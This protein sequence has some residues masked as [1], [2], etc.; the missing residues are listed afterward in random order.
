MAT[1]H[2]KIIRAIEEF[3]YFL[4]Y[5]QDEYYQALKQIN[6]KAGWNIKYFEN[7]ILQLPIELH[8]NLYDSIYPKL[9]EDSPATDEEIVHTF[10]NCLDHFKDLASVFKKIEKA[11][12]KNDEDKVLD[13]AEGLVHEL[14]L[15]AIYKLEEVIQLAVEDLSLKSSVK[16][17]NIQNIFDGEFIIGIITSTPEEFRAVKEKIDDKEYLPSY[18]NDSQIYITGVFKNNTKSLRVILTQAHHQGGAAS[19][20]AT[21]KL[22][23]RFKPS[24]VAML[25]HAAGNKNLINTL[26]IGDLLITSFAVDYD[27]ISAIE[28]KTM[29]GDEPKVRLKD[30]KNTIDADATILQLITRYLEEPDNL[31]RIKD[32]FHSSAIFENDLNYKVGLLV[33]GNALVRSDNWF[34]KIAEDNS[35]MI[36]LDMETYSFYYSAKY[37]VLKDKPFYI[38]I[39]SVSDYGGHNTNYPEK[40]KNHQIRVNYAVHTST[41]LF[42]EFALKHFPI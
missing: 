3:K 29:E 39:K 34:S 30:R 6:S 16:T 13:T 25:G 20:N 33:S 4:N 41:N 28:N 31:K 24:L 35:G 40:I 15:K 21:T 2:T 11:K 14:L 8:G 1:K 23:L 36:G 22:I 5:Y 18:S 7:E 42:Y 32:N 17:E 12:E 26:Q 37:T 38:S 10:K 19:A 27:L 9:I